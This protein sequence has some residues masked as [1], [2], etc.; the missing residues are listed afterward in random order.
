MDYVEWVEQVFGA[1]MA[2]DDGAM[3]RTSVMAIAGQLG[4]GEVTW[5][6]VAR[7]DDPK[8]EG[9]MDA[10]QDLEIVGVEMPNIAQIAI[11][12]TTRDVAHVGF[13]QAVW[14]AAFEPVLDPVA[15][16]LLS[17]LVE[18]S[19]E[20]GHVSARLVK[21]PLLG[22]WPL[23]GLGAPSGRDPV[24]LANS[25]AWSLKDKGLV[26]G[27]WAGQ[28]PLI[29]P[30]LLGVI[31]VTKVDDLEWQERL[32]GLV[33]E[34]ETTSVEFKRELDLGNDEG[35]RRLVRSVLALANT[36]ASGQ[37]Y[38]VI[39]YD[40]KSHAF[41]Q[42]VDPGVTGD[43]IED[44]LAAYADPVP[45]T[46]YQTVGVAGGTVGIIEIVR[47]AEHLPYRA[48]RDMRAVP[49]GTVLVRHGSH[50]EL[51][52]ERELADIVREGRLARGEHVE[53]ASDDD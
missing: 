37:R 39:G 46:R 21:C 22:A 27:R 8:L 16:R 30:A 13:R 10:M 51:P 25:G 20:Q 3:G 29:F 17:A 41:A 1:V 34:W 40:P 2:L 24:Q 47:N 45:A 11:T 26:R 14:P 33:E 49:A 4:F 15:S 43:R 28:D 38:L 36:K 23:A 48:R 19:V 50:I 32:P 53:D 35:K 18:Q 42:S 12:Q 9:L 44:V 52:T 5:D 31:R 7:R 6:D